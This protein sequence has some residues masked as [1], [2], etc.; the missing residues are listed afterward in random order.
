MYTYNN[1]MY[2]KILYMDKGI[3]D[4]ELLVL[5][6]LPTLDNVT[7]IIVVITLLL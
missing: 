2:K 3:K 1:Y 5:R 4:R 6:R 7:H